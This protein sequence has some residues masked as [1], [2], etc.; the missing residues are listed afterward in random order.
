[1]FRGPGVDLGRKDVDSRLVLVEAVG[2]ELGYLPNGLALGQGRQYHLVPAGFQQLLAHV[3][4]V[5][6][7][8]DVEHLDP[9]GFQHAADPVGHQVGAQVADVGVAVHGGAAGVHANQSRLNRLDFFR[10]LGK[11]IEEA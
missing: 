5:G 11:G 8:L 2:V 9:A 10:L 7:V 1:M 3:P 6:D 4:D